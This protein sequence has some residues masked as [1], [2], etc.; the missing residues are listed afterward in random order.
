MKHS[1]FRCEPPFVG[2]EAISWSC[3]QQKTRN[4][5]QDKGFGW[6]WREDLNL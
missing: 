6:S 4:R 3:W 2:I 5:L 1:G